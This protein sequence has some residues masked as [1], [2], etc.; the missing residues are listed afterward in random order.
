MLTSRCEPNDILIVLKDILQYNHECNTLLIDKA[1]ELGVEFPSDASKLLCHIF[2]AH[3]IW[4]NRIN[5]LPIG[6]KV[7]DV[8][9]VKDW[10]TIDS[11]NLK[12]S[13]DIIDDRQ[14]TEVLRYSNSQGEEFENTIEQIL[15]HVANHGTYHRGQIA[16]IMRERDLEPIPTDF[17]FLR[18]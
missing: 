18:R 17:I 6:V 13:L 7:F 11:R 15:L 1:K 4:N 14:V 16:W 12:T 8:H 3:I 2:N 5:K 9:P 10:S